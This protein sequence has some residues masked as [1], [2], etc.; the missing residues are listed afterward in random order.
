MQ[1]LIAWWSSPFL[2]PSGEPL[3]NMR[4]LKPRQK[5]EVRAL[6]AKAAIKR[7][8]KLASR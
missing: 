4:R 2:R 6:R 5:A 7:A 1:D 3:G 8:H